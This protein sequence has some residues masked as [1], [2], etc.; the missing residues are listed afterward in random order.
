MIYVIDVLENFPPI[1]ARQYINCCLAINKT[2]FSAVRLKMGVWW[3]LVALALTIAAVQSEPR[4][5]SSSLLADRI[6]RLERNVLKLTD[7]VGM[8]EI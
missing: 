3:I 4:D 5:K 7:Q 6:D 8:N 2:Y 1:K